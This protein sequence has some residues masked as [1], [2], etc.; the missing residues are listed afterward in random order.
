MNRSCLTWWLIMAGC[1]CLCLSGC[2]PQ[3]QQTSPP[4]SETGGQAAAPRT[5]PAPRGSVDEGTIVAMGDSLTAGLGVP[6]G[7]AYPAQLER[8]LR[9]DGYAFKVINAGVSG[10]T[11]SG[12]RTRTEWMLTG[13]LGDSYT[14]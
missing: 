11:S 2:K 8:K 5:S 13:A 4:A 6:E 12:A 9:A 1:L 7:Q 10:E 3:T 14:P